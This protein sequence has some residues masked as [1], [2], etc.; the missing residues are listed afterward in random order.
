MEGSQCVH[1]SRHAPR[2]PPG[3]SPPWAAS[4]P[5]RHLAQPELIEETLASDLDDETTDA[6]APKPAIEG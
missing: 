3:L 1:V 6:I 5:L 2:S 4:E